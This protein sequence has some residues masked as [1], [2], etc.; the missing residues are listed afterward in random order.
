MFVSIK[1]TPA[2][3]KDIAYLGKLVDDMKI[4]EEPSLQ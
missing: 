1:I 4:N 3:T 2:E